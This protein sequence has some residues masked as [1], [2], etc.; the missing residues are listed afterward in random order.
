MAVDLYSAA[1]VADPFT[2]SYPPDDTGSDGLSVAKV[3]TSRGLIAGYQHTFTTNDALLALS[4]TPWITG[5]NWYSS[6]DSPAPNG[7]IKVASSAYV[8]GGHEFEGSELDVENSRVWFWNSWG[9]GYGIGGRMW[10]SFGTF[11]RMLHEEG[12]VTVFVPRGQPAPQPQGDPADVAL[13]SAFRADGWVTGRH[14][15][16]NGR[17]AKAAAAWLK[18]KNL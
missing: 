7:E 18:A 1:T 12:D 9:P 8:R 6:F 3:L 15:G 13:A 11:D 5:M 4:Q 10:M 2:G 16:S 17:V 14:V